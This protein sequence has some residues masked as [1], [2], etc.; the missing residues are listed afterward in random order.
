[1]T[2][3]W[4]LYDKGCVPLPYLASNNNQSAIIHSYGWLSGS[5]E[6]WQ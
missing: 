3:E 2:S 6:V 4:G 1:M 5:L